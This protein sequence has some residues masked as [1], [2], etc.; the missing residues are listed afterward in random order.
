MHNNRKNYSMYWPSVILALK[1]QWP[2]GMF[3]C[4]CCMYILLVTAINYEIAFVSSSSYAS[5]CII[6]VYRSWFILLYF[7]SERK[8]VFPLVTN[9][10]PNDSK[11][12]TKWWVVFCNVCNGRNVFRPRCVG[13]GS[14]SLEELPAHYYH[15]YSFRMNFQFSCGYLGVE[16][17]IVRMRSISH[18]VW[19]RVN[20]TILI[21]V[22]IPSQ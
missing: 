21:H 18:G 22:K 3:H 12:N 2:K 11:D 4:W 8:W 14:F 15:N 20:D 6:H 19:W 5:V 17:Q 7:I 9:C 10:Q 1:A 16:K 13:Y